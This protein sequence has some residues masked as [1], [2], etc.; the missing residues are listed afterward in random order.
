MSDVK[1]SPLPSTTA[2][3]KASSSP[4]QSLIL[5]LSC[6]DRS[7]IV[8]SVTGWLASR[9]FDI[10]DSAQYGD[11]DTGRFFMRVHANGPKGR[12]VDLNG[13]RGEFERDVGGKMG[14]E[15]EI[16][17]EGRKGKV[18]LMVSKIGHC[19]HDLLYRHSVGTLPVSIPCIVSNHTTFATL[20]AQH[21]IPFHH[22]PIDGQHTKEWQEEQILQLIEEHDIDLV[23]L[24]RYMQI[25]S[26][27][28]CEV[29]RGKMIN[30]HHSFLPSFKGAK[31]Y[32]QAHQ[33]GVKLIGATAHLVTS[34]LDEGNIIQQD[35]ER[36]S[37]SDSPSDLVKKGSEIETRVLARAVTWF[38]E[39]RV[40]VNGNKTVVFD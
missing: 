39:H 20:A 1:H 18:M 25:L 30:I 13:L 23:V 7:G 22:L 29:M 4:H 8:H 34:D 6:P 38:A 40:L 15:F 35:V 37:H 11:P 5:T 24:A 3:G 12:V 2:T 17:D 36:V 27:K 19:I 32:H 9:S 33:R 31:P 28:L 26:P 14:M 16:H 10:R 21:G